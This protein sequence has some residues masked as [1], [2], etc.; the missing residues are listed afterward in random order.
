M[1]GKQTWQNDDFTW[2][3]PT[4]NVTWPFDQ[5][6]LWVTRFTYRR[7]S[8]CKHLSHHRLSVFNWKD[9]FPVHNLVFL[10]KKSHETTI[11]DKY[12]A[13]LKKISSKFKGT[14][15]LWDIKW[16]CFKFSMDSM[17]WFLDIRV[18]SENVESF[19]WHVL[20]YVRLQAK[21]F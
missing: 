16:K 8:A 7:R 21:V 18:K 9:K 4:Y 2:W 3:A 11:I 6:A 13:I 15:H 20:F 14:V 1:H 10:K 5:V 12:T 17:F 19:L